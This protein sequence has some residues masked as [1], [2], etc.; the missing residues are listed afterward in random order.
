MKSTKRPESEATLLDLPLQP[1]RRN[2][3]VMAGVAGV[4]MASD[5]AFAQPTSGK[6]RAGAANFA[7]GNVKVS[8]ETG[9][10]ALT[11]GMVVREGQT[12]ET[13]VN[14][15]V[16]VIFDDGGFLAVRPSSRILIEKAKISGAFDDSLS[17]SLLSGALRSVTGWIGKFDKHNYQLS[18]ATATVGIR[19]TDHELATI[20]A[21]EE[22]NGEIPGIHNWVHEGGT[23][24]RSSGGEI[25]IEP[26]HAAWA[27]H[28]GEA[29][30]A[31]IA[32]PRFL[33]QR[34]TRHEEKIEAHARR[35]HEIIEMR[36]RKRGM[37][38]EG[39]RLGD[40]QR[41]H[42]ELKA[43]G[44]RDESERIKHLRPENEQPL[45]RHRKWR[46]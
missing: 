14:S 44:D 21:G 8:D 18:T 45:H 28:S 9:S 43:L 32:I 20:S 6:R 23:T 12:I 19:G 37:L 24:L 25:D 39:E 36:M 10:R 46:E 7:E 22:R 33:H 34:R 1:T 5:L 29:P 3:C 30:R 41:R 15:E 31:H 27:P 42:Q 13:A 16:H 4:S 38:K 35:I 26:G 2:L 11:V 40:A 17:I